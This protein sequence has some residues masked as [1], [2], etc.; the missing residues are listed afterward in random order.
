M[1]FFFQISNLPT[2]SSK[3]ITPR[4]LHLKWEIREKKAVRVS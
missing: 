2:A 4:K 3:K 1:W